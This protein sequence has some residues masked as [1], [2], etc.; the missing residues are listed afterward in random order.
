ML[1][2]FREAAVVAGME[3]LSGGEAVDGFGFDSVCADSRQVR[4][5]ALFVALGGE[6][7]DGHGFVRD[8]LKAGAAGAIV[9]KSKLAAF[10]LSDAARRDFVLLAAC[11]SLAAL[12]RLAAVYL[13]KFPNLLRIGITGSSGKTTTKELA[14]AMI[15]FERSVVF[16]EGNLNS[17]I[18]LPLS[19]FRVREG[20]EAGVFEMGMNRK[21][22]IAEL[23]AVLRPQIALITNAGSAH[24]GMLGG[25]REVALQKMAV[26]SCFTGEELA[27]LPEEGAFADFLAEGVNGNIVRFGRTASTK[28]GGAESR[29]L[30]GSV[31]LWEGKA[32]NFALPGE[33]NVMNA[34]AA[35]AVAEAAGVSGEAVRAALAAARPLPGRGELV[36]GGVTVV[37][38]CY[39]ANPDSMEKAISLCDG[40]A[41]RGRRVYV[42][43]SMLELGDD[44]ERAHEKLGERLARSKADLIFLF[45]E[46]TKAAREKLCCA[47]DK[48]VFHTNDIEELKVKV[49]ESARE[50][51]TFL[52]KGS[53]TCALERIMP[54]HVC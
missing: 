46:E 20:H 4:P 24:A 39:N 18:G 9:E 37:N 16:N 11:D 25:E 34:L 36:V 43:A 32:V 50:G 54:V 15:G 52:L 31:L 3:L 26:F 7:S 33:Y 22:E 49:R 10:G 12:Q 23:S 2:S 47:K 41:L 6:R 42:I 53:R 45:G 8:A 13:D 19:L 21:G 17:D 44:S 5:G 51:D 14:A 1:M 38:D 29:G 27:V 48:F 40:A 28:F 30:S 35:A